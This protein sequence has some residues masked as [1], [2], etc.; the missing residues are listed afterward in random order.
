MFGRGYSGL[1]FLLKEKYFSMGGRLFG[2]V[3]GSFGVGDFL[4]GGR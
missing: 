3:E 2:C 1:V 4:R